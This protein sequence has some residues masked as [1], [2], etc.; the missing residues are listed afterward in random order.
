MTTQAPEVEV[1]APETTTSET[2]SNAAEPASGSRCKHRYQNGKRCRLPASE[3]QLGLCPRHFRQ[4]LASGLPASDDFADLSTDLLPP[5]TE[6]L[7][8]EDLCKY[9][10]RLLILMTMGRIG[11]R[12]AAVL[13][14]IANQ[15]LHSHVAA[16]KELAD[17][18]SSQPFIFDLPRPKRD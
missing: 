12:R 13:A 17:E 4:R 6:F 16:E 18:Q 10:T 15:L 8:A 11:P 2:Q 3:P 5:G 9:L 14:Y 7:S 1:L